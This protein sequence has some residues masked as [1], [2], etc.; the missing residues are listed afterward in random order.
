[1]T[2][3]AFRQV[4]LTLGASTILTGV[5]FTIRQGE[6][7]GLL[8]PNGAGKTTLLRAVLGLLE[9]SAGAIQVLGRP[10]TRGNRAVGYMPQ[11]RKLAAGQSLTGW[12][13][14]A[15]AAGGW[16]W[17]L[18]MLSAAERA[19]VAWALD[20][21]G[22]SALARRPL[23]SLSGG[24]RQRLLISQALLGRPKLL[25]LDEPLM[26]LDPAHQQGIVD[27]VKRLQTEFGMAVVFSAHEL[28][29]LL[30]AMDKVLYLGQGQAVLGEVDDVVTTA[31]LS[32][33]Y[34]SSI[35]VLRLGSR[36]F[37]MN[38]NAEAEVEAHRHDA[39]HGDHAFEAA[40]RHA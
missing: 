20:K 7:V 22:A 28:N 15:G 26:S 32:R 3:V 13:F 21:V 40:H 6:F 38:G 34:G 5:D 19:E 9:P 16:R 24:E 11:N 2:A 39:D 10:A 18:P 27:L 8:G 33:L 31:V 29:P 4:S 1:M 23:G 36:I 17:G 37:V 35:E 25:L 14:V 12:D 30:G